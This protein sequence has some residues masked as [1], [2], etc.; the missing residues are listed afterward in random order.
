MDKNPL[1]K[2][3]NSDSVRYVVK[4]G[5]VYD[6]NTMNQIWPEELAATPFTF[7]AWSNPPV[8]KP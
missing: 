2:I 4:N 3:E 5:V 6:G 8:G 1:D 7:Q